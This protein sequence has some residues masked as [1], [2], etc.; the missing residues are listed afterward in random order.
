MCRAESNPQDPSGKCCGMHPTVALI[1][2]DGSITVLNDGRLTC[3]LRYYGVSPWEIEVMYGYVVG[4]FAIVQDEIEPDD[5]NFVSYLEMQ[6]PLA[7][8]DAFFQWFEYRRWEK[9]KAVFKE[10]KRRRGSK[11]ALKISLNFA[12]NPRVTFVIDTEERQWFDNAVEKL[13]FVLELLP[14]HLEPAKL[15]AAVSEIR[16][17]FD[18]G[19]IR[20]RLYSAVSGNTEYML[21]NDAWKPVT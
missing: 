11:N 5:D 8:N 3:T 20:W 21:K 13:D 7:F 1:R 17:R 4:R 6:I 12:G 9:V 2:F 10:M 18:P 15:P 16:Y 14:Y 19:T